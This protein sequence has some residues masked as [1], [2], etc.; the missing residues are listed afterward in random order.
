MVS[1]F[2]AA[3]VDTKATASLF[4]HLQ[5]PLRDTPMSTEDEVD[6]RM[7]QRKLSPKDLIQ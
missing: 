2:A 7:T 1:G 6:V 5:F 3:H 4:W